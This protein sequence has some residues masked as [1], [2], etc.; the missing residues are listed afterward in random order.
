MP[1]LEQLLLKGYIDGKYD[2]KYSDFQ[3]VKCPICNKDYEL[4]DGIYKCNNCNN[5]FRKI[6]LATYDASKVSNSASDYLIHLLTY[7]AKCDG[8]ITS[9]ERDYIIEDINSFDMNEDQ[10]SWAYAQY[11]YARYNDY[12]QDTIISL[13]DSLN[14][15][16]DNHNLEFEILEDLV[17]LTLINNDDITDNHTTIFNDYLFLFDISNSFL[18]KTVRNTKISKAKLQ[19]TPTRNLTEFNLDKCYEILNL[20]KGCS[21]SDLKK[22]YA[23]LTKSYHPD[24]YNCEEIPEEIRK[25]LESTY[26][27]INYAYDKLKENI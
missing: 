6:G 12:N 23:Y 1:I 10:L 14:Q 7:C 16:A 21:I 22:Q 15:L 2:M 25:E 17:Y 18:E 27:Q 13:K 19:N 20:K 5:Y 24:K 26:K 8:Q 9:S 4:E 3:K 11:D